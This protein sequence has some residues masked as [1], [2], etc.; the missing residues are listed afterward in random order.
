MNDKFKDSI[1]ASNNNSFN[2]EFNLNR[3]ILDDKQD[4]I[5]L[6]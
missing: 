2:S 5:I 3:I 1:I 4:S 6:N